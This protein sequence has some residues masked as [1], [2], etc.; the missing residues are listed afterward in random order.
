M[1]KLFLSVL[2]AA[3]AVVVLLVPSPEA[4]GPGPAAAT[5]PPSVAVCPV[6]EGSGRTTRIGVA[7][8]VGGEGRFT[9]FAAGVS[10][11]A[12]SFS[13]EASGSAAV[14]VSEIAPIGVGAGLTEMPDGDVAAASVLVGTQSIAVE[15]CTPVPVPRTLIAGGSTLSGQQHQVQLMNPYAGEAMVDLIVQSDSGLEAAPQL[16]G[17]IVPSRSSEIIDLD[18]LLPGRQALAIAI[19]VASGSVM[20]SARLDVGGDGALWHSVDPALDWFVPVPAAGLAGDLV[21]ATGSTSEVEY[22]VDVYGPQGLVE[23]Q[24]EGVLPAR[25]TVSL[26]LVGMELEAASAVRVISTQPVAVFQRLISETGVALTAGSPATSSSWLLPAAGLAPGGTGS[27]LI[28]NTGLDESVVVVS[29]RRDQPATE[30][31]VVPAETTVEL[32]AIT[33]GANAYTVQGQGPLVAAWVTTGAAATAYS[34][35]VP[36]PDE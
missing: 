1:S 19:E 36:L 27:L 23:A 26:P 35:G 24:Q 14:S 5:N 21:I 29:A 31:V 30:E 7:S 15:P 17:I 2:V 3:M 18:E 9:A 13:T 12:T 6:D 16:G 25:G 33:G 8:E 22:Q 4:P 11:G 28:F 34:I 20:T 10:A 32:P